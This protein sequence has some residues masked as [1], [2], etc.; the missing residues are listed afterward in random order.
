MANGDP[1]ILERYNRFS[2]GKQVKLWGPILSAGCTQIGK[3]LPALTRMKIDYTK[4]KH[5]FHVT[6]PPA[7]AGNFFLKI[8]ECCLYIKR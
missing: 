5:E 1:R 3:V 4:S 7:I 6:Q 8:E 2:E